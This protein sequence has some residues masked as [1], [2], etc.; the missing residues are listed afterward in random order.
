[1]TIVEARERLRTA[2]MAVC[3]GL[4]LEWAIEN[5]LKPEKPL[6]GN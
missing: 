1:M 4:P 6:E 2:D 5:I 3:F